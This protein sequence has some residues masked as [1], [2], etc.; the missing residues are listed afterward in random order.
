MSLNDRM[1]YRT[2][3]RSVAEPAP[4]PGIYL[5]STDFFTVDYLLRATVTTPENRLSDL[6]N[7]SLPVID[8]RP[9]TATHYR[10]GGS[11]DLAGSYGY[12]IKARL[13]LAIPLA[14][15]DRPTPAENNEWRPTFQRI[16]WAGI[17]PYRVTGTV[18]GEAGRDPHVA[19]RLLDK[20]FLPITDATIDL[21]D[22]GERSCAVLLAN[23]AYM[24]VLAVQDSDSR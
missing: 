22:G 4:D 18:H 2:A 9:E 8:V 1:L 20:Q 6:L 12:V 15:P 17:G 5:L 7:S 13:L 11:T 16:C 10:D 14:E 19:F 24:D 3:V 23:R 21:P